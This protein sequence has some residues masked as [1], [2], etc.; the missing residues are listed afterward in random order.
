EVT[1]QVPRA[2]RAVK[3]YRSVGNGLFVPFSVTGAADLEESRRATNMELDARLVHGQTRAMRDALDTP[4]TWGYRVY[5]DADDGTHFDYAPFDAPDDFDLQQ[6]QLQE[7]SPAVA[8]TWVQM[9]MRREVA[10][11]LQRE[12]IELIGRFRQRP[13][14]EGPGVRDYLVRVALAPLADEDG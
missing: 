14:D 7:G 3:M 10:K 5:R 8:S 1:R 12:L 13:L 6:L 9:P 11:E 2:G 4:A